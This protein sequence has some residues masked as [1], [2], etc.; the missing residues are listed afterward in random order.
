MGKRSALAAVAVCATAAI[1]GAAAQAA[2]P[3][4]TTA[5][6]DAV[7]VGDGT[8][9][10]RQHLRELQVIA[11]ANGGTRATGTQGHADSLAYVKSR[12]DATG[13]FTTSTQPFTATV[14]TPLAAPTLSATPPAAEPWTASEDYDYMEFSG[15]G[16]VTDAPIAVID[17]AEPTTTAS[18]SSSGCEASDFPAGGIAGKV[19][20]MQRGTCDFGLKVQNAE[21]AGAVASIVFNEG[22]IGDPDRQGLINGTLGGYD[23]TKPA[24]DATYAVGRYLVDHPD[25]RSRSRPRR[26]PTTCRR[27]T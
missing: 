25:A 20:V 21:A 1:G 23:I 6:Q 15:S 11:D 7:Q 12:L 9:G 10:I 17:F 2:T 14:F 22:T 16:T 18:T 26:G 24:L 19:A 3:V 13:Y 8:S 4:D 5:L 27:T